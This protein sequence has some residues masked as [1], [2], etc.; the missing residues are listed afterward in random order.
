MAIA[1]PFQT[2][3]LRYSVPALDKTN[4]FYDQF[5]RD[6]QQAYRTVTTGL[7]DNKNMFGAGRDF[8]KNRFQ[9]VYNKYL[10]DEGTAMA[11]GQTYNKS[12]YDYVREYDFGGDYRSQTPQQR[13]FDRPFVLQPRFMRRF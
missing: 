7:A 9:E 2:Y 8:I 13:G 4:P 1:D 10:A 5:S 6:P 11:Q 3:A 12:F